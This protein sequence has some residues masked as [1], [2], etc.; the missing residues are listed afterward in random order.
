M[1]LPKLKSPPAPLP[2]L[3]VSL[4]VVLFPLTVLLASAIV[5]P[6]EKTPPPP[7]QQLFVTAAVLPSTWLLSSVS[8][9]PS[10]YTPPSPAHQPGVGTVAE[11]LGP[12]AVLTTL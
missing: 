7:L 6:F 2:L 4:T 1:T 5:P 12:I 10:S 9:P 3:L 8:W 11:L